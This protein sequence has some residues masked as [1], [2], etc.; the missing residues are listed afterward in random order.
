MPQSPE[1]VRDTYTPE[2]LVRRVQEMRR[3]YQG[4][5]LSAALFNDFVS[6]FRFHDDVG[7]LWSVGAN[8]GQWYRWDRTQW[9]QAPPPRSLTLVNDEIQRSSAWMTTAAA[10]SRPAPA[11]QAPAPAANVCGGCGAPW[12]PGAKFCTRCGK[13]AAAP[14]QSAP[15]PS[16][17]PRC[18]KVISQGTK[19]CTGCGT[20]VAQ[21]SAR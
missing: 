10:A 9:T 16:A 19:F 4:G 11:A 14:A 18:N 8:S 13:P 12:K 6:A 17:C 1:L 2:E 3:L 20:P 15:R 7:H 21:S 5:A